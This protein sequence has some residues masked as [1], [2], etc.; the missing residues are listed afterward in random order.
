MYTNLVQAS[1]LN[2]IDTV[3]HQRWNHGTAW[4]SIVCQ[5]ALEAQWM[6]TQNTNTSN[7]LNFTICLSFSSTWCPSSRWTDS[8][9]EQCSTTHWL[10]FTPWA[11][12]NIETIWKNTVRY[13]NCTVIDWS[14]VAV[15]ADGR[16]AQYQ[17]CLEQE[18]IWLCW[19]LANKKH[20][21]HS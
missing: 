1:L 7:I 8:E 17:Q 2:F 11:I 16:W 6:I 20:F 5:S 9:P 19:S 12:L 15:C 10:C 18:C 3:D 4:R 21:P 13:I 14:E